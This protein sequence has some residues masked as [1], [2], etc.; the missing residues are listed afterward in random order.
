[1]NKT[2]LNKIIAQNIKDYIDALGK[3]QKWVYERSGIPKATFYKLL[4]G[5]GDLNKT[6]PKLNKLFR[7]EDPFYFYQENIKLPRSI[8]EIN[9]SSSILNCSAASYTG[10]D[11]PQFKDSMNILNDII[12][13]INRLENAKEVGFTR[14]PVQETDFYLE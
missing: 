14:P 9:E 11:G 5:E 13:I 4:N 10:A 3:S 2:N 6:V 12:N 8:K 7:I 1:M